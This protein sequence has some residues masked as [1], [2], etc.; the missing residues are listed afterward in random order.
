MINFYRKPLFN[1]AS[2]TLVGINIELKYETFKA[3]NVTQLTINTS[4]KHCLK[5]VFPHFFQIEHISLMVFSR[6]TYKRQ[7][8]PQLF[9]A[10]ESVLHQ[11]S[12]RSKTYKCC[13]CQCSQII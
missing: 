5:Q 3:L 10:N 4:K 12:Q 2:T 8:T 1:N 7:P 11:V 6:N 9:V 13:F